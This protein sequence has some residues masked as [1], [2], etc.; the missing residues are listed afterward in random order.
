MAAIGWVLA[1]FGFWHGA[2]QIREFTLVAE[3]IDWELQSGIT[4][5]AWA[6][7]GQIPAPEIRVTEGDLVRVNFV[8]NLPAPSTVHFHG[9]NLTPDM[10]GPV[11]LNQAAVEPG[12]TFTYEFVA[13][14]SGTRWFHSHTD[15]TNQVMLGLYGSFIV[16]PKEPQVEFDREYTYV[17]SEWDAELTPDVALGLAPRGPRDSQLRGGELGTDYFLFNGRMHDAIEPMIVKEG[18]RVLIRLINAGT[19]IHP[20]HTHGHSFRVVA[21]DGNF[22]PEAAQ[23]TKDTI[24]IAPGERYDLLLVADNPGVWMVHCHI[25]NHADNGMMTIIQYEGVLPSGP[26]AE[27]WNPETGGLAV[28]SKDPA[29]DGATHMGHGD[30]AIVA[31]P[32]I[33]IVETEAP[34]ESQSSTEVLSGECHGR[35]CRQPLRTVRGDGRGRH[36]CCVR[37]QRRKLAQRRR[38]PGNDRIWS[39]WIGRGIHL[40][41]RD[42]GDVQSDLYPASQAGDV[43]CDHGCGGSSALTRRNCARRIAGGSEIDAHWMINKEATGS[44]LSDGS[45][46]GDKSRLILHMTE[47]NM[48]TRRTVLKGAVIAGAAA[49]PAVSG[50]GRA[51]AQDASPV[52]SPEVVAARANCSRRGTD[53]SACGCGGC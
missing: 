25:E 22:V 29:L 34:E 7:N 14:P 1:R 19:T 35:T 42:P 15:V 49:V 26:L 39:N 10:D 48:T 53:E 12:E 38:W 23:I 41:I 40:H 46:L 33:E 37:Q 44:I 9:V 2:Q 47:E 36:D 50:L 31:S 45:P 17:L 6:Y 18:E 4:V 43:C 30:P 3:E 21:T 27:G 51:L 5:K 11:G 13:T 16:E 24:A 28:P 52:A 20:F 32:V 8:N